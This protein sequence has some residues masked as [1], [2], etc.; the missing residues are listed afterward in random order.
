MEETDI[1]KNE[2]QKKSILRPKTSKKVSISEKTGKHINTGLN[3]N[4]YIIKTPNIEKNKKNNNLIFS[5]FDFNNDYLKKEEKS[6]KI[7]LKNLNNINLFEKKVDDLYDWG[8]LFNNFKPIRSYISLQKSTQTK[9]GRKTRN[10]NLEEYESPIVLVDLP[11]SQIN[12]FFRRNSRNHAPFF[13]SY[14]EKMQLVVSSL[15]LK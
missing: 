11:E 6:F 7:K 14:N 8:N 9:Q 10:K 13:P 12:F 4:N 5:K 1:K 2:I 15:F 3:S